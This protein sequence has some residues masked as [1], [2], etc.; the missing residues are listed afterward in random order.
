[1]G[2]EPEPKQ[3]SSSDKKIGR[4]GFLRLLGLGVAG[5]VVGA[6]LEKKMEP[7]A[8]Q[9]L[10]EVDK[11]LLEKFRLY[12]QLTRGEIGLRMEPVDANFAEKIWQEVLNL[13]ESGTL[14]EYRRGVDERGNV[15]FKVDTG[16]GFIF[17]GQEATLEYIPRRINAAEM[18]KMQVGGNEIYIA[19]YTTT[20]Q[21]RTP[22]GGTESVVETNYVF[23]DREGEPI[24]KLDP[25]DP[26]DRI[27]QD[28][29]A[30]Q[31]FAATK[32]L[33]RSGELIQT[34]VWTGR[35]E[36]TGKIYGIVIPIETWYWERDAN[37]QLRLRGVGLFKI[38]EEFYRGVFTKTGLMY[39]EENFGHPVAPIPTTETEITSDKK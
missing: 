11:F 34:V 35:Y 24:Y 17:Q 32:A 13:E 3:P 27:T 19:P 10:K 9:G 23:V 18:V 25:Y 31:L 38:G 6:A 16:R 37:D 22:D 1:M 8:G 7:L 5:G 30:S 21:R 36:D 39:M 26:N 2:S 15:F 20:R 14:Q 29:S 28:L 4:S 33:M 12:L